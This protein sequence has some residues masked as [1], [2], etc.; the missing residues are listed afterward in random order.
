MTREKAKE[1]FNTEAC[2]ETEW[3]SDTTKNSFDELIDKIYDD[4]ESQL[5]ELQP[6]TCEGCIHYGFS[7]IFDSHTCGCKDEC[8][9]RKIIV[10]NKYKDHYEKE[11]NQ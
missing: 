8:V 6:K 9:R 1:Y 5:K 4:F 2:G 3:L 11:S 7:T 10:A